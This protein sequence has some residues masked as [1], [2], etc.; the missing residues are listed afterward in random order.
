MH[1]CFLQFFF[2]NYYFKIYNIFTVFKKVNFTKDQYSIE[3]LH[4][5]SKKKELRRKGC[6]FEQSNYIA[7]ETSHTIFTIVFPPLEKKKDTEQKAR[8]KSL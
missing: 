2:Y 1:V 3:E 4:I 5:F 7:S 6:F 8:I